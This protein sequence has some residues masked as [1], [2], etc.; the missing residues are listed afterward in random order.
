MNVRV[1][2]VDPG[3]MTAGYGIVEK[4]GTRLAA[5]AYGALTTN[6]K[7]SYPER[8]RKIYDQLA[9]VIQRYR[10]DSMAIEEVFGGKSVQSAIKM[11]EGRAIAILCAAQAGLPVFEY[12]TRTVKKSTVGSGAAHKSQ[13]QHM[14]KVILNLP[15]VPEPEDAADALALAICHCN[16]A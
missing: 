14:V 2:G 16:R 3:T 4:K 7:D 11:G 6:R 9:A 13:V 15:D 12:A 8:L 10:P 5:V 1:L